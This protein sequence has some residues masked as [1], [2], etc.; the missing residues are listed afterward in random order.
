MADSL[1]VEAT[2]RPDE[3]VIILTRLHDFSGLRSSLFLRRFI[4]PV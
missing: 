1:F 4:R 2:L 3:N